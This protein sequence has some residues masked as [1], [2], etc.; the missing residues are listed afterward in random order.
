MEDKEKIRNI[1]DLTLDLEV[2]HERA[3]VMVSNID[4]YYF[5]L[6]ED[7]FKLFYFEHY[8][9]EFGILAEYV[10]KM[11]DQLKEIRELLNVK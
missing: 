6:K 4:Q 11:G 2:S 3:R 9:I 10:Y 7:N 8:G 1:D 5:D